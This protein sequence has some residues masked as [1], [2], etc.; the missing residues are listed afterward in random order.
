MKYS[1]DLVIF[2]YIFEFKCLHMKYI[3]LALTVVFSFFSFGQELDPGYAATRSY[4]Q[5]KD[6]SKIP[7]KK[8]VI[9]CED[10]CY[11]M[12]RHSSICDVKPIAEIEGFSKGNDVRWM[13]PKEFRRIGL[14]PIRGY[15]W[16]VVFFYP[17]VPGPGLFIFM[18]I[19]KRKRVKRM[20][21]TMKLK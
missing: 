11:Y 20:Y 6:G 12:L 15:L 13:D 10:Q 2:T 21:L 1:F 3:V 17:L 8:P 9:I 18:D 19:A 16:G 7:V 4:I 5:F 14:K